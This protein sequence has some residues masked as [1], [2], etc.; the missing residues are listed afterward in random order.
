MC[1]GHSQHES[2][3][4]ITFISMI[5]ALILPALQAANE[6][7]GWPAWAVLLLWLVGT[8]VAAFAL[9]FTLVGLSELMHRIELWRTHRRK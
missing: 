1:I 4:F 3:V 6:H 2:L 5:A 8:I 9:F 7:L